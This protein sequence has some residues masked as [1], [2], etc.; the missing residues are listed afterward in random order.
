M[1]LLILL[2]LS[3]YSNSTNLYSDTAKSPL[4][5]KYQISGTEIEISNIKCKISGT[6]IEISNI[7]YQVPGKQ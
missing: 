2:T 5:L 4:R 7:K 6:E 1:V 3:K